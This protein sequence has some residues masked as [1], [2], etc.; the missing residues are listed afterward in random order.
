MRRLR[1]FCDVCVRPPH[2]AGEGLGVGLSH[3]SYAHRTDGDH[4]RVAVEVA[5][6][7]KAS[8]A[9]AGE[10]AEAGL[11]R[12]RQTSKAPAPSAVATP[13]STVA[14]GAPSAS[15]IAPIRTAPK[16]LTF[17]VIW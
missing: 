2:R 17:Q 11:R 6:G 16:R 5:L 12:G 8:G 4:L 3:G 15:A 10:G 13:A 7:D 9:A 14:V 1:V